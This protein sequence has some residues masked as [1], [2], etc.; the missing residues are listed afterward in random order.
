M[1]EHPFP[2]EPPV[3]QK[4]K[5]APEP[6]QADRLRTLTG[7][8]QNSAHVEVASA[9]DFSIGLLSDTC[10]F[11]ATQRRPFRMAGLADIHALGGS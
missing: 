1:E 6:L 5:G 9:T 7:K 4:A 8:A 3:F 2:F 11:Q 10:L